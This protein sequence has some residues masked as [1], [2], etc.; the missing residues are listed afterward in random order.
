MEFIAYKSNETY[1]NKYYQI[2]QELFIKKIFFKDFTLTLLNIF[3][4]HI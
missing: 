2:P 1:E 4:V 3:I